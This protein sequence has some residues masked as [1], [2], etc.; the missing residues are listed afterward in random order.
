MLEKNILKNRFSLFS[1]SFRLI[2]PI[3]RFLIKISGTGKIKP[4]VDKKHFF[5]ELKNPP[6]KVLNDLVSESQPQEPPLFT[7]TFDQ[8]SSTGNYNVNQDFAT[9]PFQDDPFDVDPF[10]ENDFMKQDP[11]DTELSNDFRFSQTH[12]KNTFITHLSKSPKSSTLEKQMSLISTSIRNV[13]FSKQNTF[14]VQFDKFEDKKLNKLSQ[15][16]ENPSLDLSSESECAP[17]PPPRPATNLT[18]IKPPPLP[19]KKQPGVLNM[20]P[21]PRP[22]HTEDSHYDYMDHYETAPNSLEFIKNL[23]T[24]PP[25]PVPARKSKFESDFTAVPERPKKQFNLQQQEDDYLTPVSFLPPKENVAR[26]TGPLLLP[27]PQ[28]SNRKH[29][30]PVT[31]AS[32]LENKT[33]SVNT[34]TSNSITN[35]MHS[36]KS[37]E[38]LDIT[39]SQLTLSGLN[40]LAAK[41]NIPANQ[42]SNMTLVQLTNYLSNFIKSAKHADSSRNSTSPTFHADFAAN[43]NN[44]NITTTTGTTN[45]TYDRYAVFRELIQEEIKQTKIDTEPEEITENPQTPTTLDQTLNNLD[46]KTLNEND[47]IVDKYAALREIVENEI[48]QNQIINEKDNE[49]EEEEEEEEED[50]NKNESDKVINNDEKANIDV[51]IENETNIINTEKSIKDKEESEIITSKDQVIEYNTTSEKID[52]KATTPVK[53]PV[54]KTVKSPIPIAVTDVIQN[55]TRLNSG[56]LSDVISGSS[57]EIDNTGSTSEVAKKSTDATGL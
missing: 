14:D 47:Q 31:V 15:L 35:Q 52:L 46:T 42:L 32:L 20:K 7:A 40:E 13:Q 38:G 33:T 18:T 39:L 43:F 57:P 5:Q 51:K 4:Y 10:V 50:N 25:L 17:E 1:F 6:K 22:P 54:T 23:D 8:N 56:S 34:S 53:S 3:K 24:S 26:H 9:D 12:D 41:L 11:F 36:E 45:E 28:K 16:H 37:L 49:E 21:P 29:A 19:P 44:L 30:T 48:K 55:N 2:I 27:P